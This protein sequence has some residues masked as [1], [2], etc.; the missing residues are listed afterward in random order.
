MLLIVV[1]TPPSLR[2]WLLASMIGG[3]VFAV[4]IHAWHA[5]HPS[6]VP[7]TSGE[8]Y[9]RPEINLSSIPVQAN[10]GGLIFMVGSVFI[11]IAGL[12]SWHWFF[13]AAAAGGVL[14]GVLLFVWHAR[15]PSR[16]LPRNRISLR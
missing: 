14:T 10:I 12:P 3:T 4:V 9:R 2:G 13:L 11:V 16:G 7:M 5:R 6:H 15:H 8:D 1:F